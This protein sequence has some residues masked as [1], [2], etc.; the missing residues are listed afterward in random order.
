MITVTENAARRFRSCSRSS[1]PTAAA[2][3]SASRPAAVRA[4]STCSRGKPA[5][6]ETDLVFDGP[7]RRARLGRSAQPPAAR[8]HDAR[9][10][11][12]PDEPRLHLQ[13]PERQEHVRLRDVVHRVAC[14]S[15]QHDA[16]AQQ[17]WDYVHIHRDH[18][19]TRHTRVQVRLRHRRRSRTR[20]RRARTRTSSGS[21]RR[22]RTSPTWLLEWRL[23]A[24]RA[25][26]D[27]D[28][29]DVAR[30]SSTR[31]STTRTSATTRR[32]RRSR[33]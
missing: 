26:A 8:R 9:L 3:A 10:R 11:H 16:R 30:T 4:S 1:T 5:P 24:Y 32:R 33:R 29:A 25:L 28:G 17:R 19:T 12:E 27:D 6:R 21:S 15:P 20:S 18:R 2:C 14:A 7:E 22:R 31:R 23:K 13:E